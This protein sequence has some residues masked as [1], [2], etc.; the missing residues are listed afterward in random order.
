MLTRDPYVAALEKRAFQEW[1]ENEA[2]EKS[3][4]AVNAANREHEKIKSDSRQQLGELFSNAGGLESE[5]TKTVKELF[6]GAEGDKETSSP[7][8]KVARHCFNST[9]MLKQA[10]P[11]YKE[12]VMRSFCDELEKIDAAR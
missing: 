4:W 1:A 10:S 5:A 12:L 6:P 9:T 3:N 11:I 2:D 8:I 7:F